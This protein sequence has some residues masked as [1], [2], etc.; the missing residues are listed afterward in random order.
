MMKI[1]MLIN[2]IAPM[3]FIFV[4]V[5]GL[6]N[7][8]FATTFQL[9]TEELPPYSMMEDNQPVGIS[10]EIVSL[11]FEKAQLDYE[12]RVVPWKRAFNTLQNKV[13]SCAFPVQR[14][15]EREV[16]FHWISPILITHTAFYT[17]KHS[18]LRIRTLED[19]RYLEIGS[20]GGSAIVDYLSNL[21]FI[22]R[23]TT[24]E[25]NNIHKLI[26]NRIDIWAADTNTAK[27]YSK[28]NNVQLKRHVVFFTTLRALACNIGVP[29]AVIEKLQITLKNMYEDGSISAV[30]NKYQ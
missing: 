28:K 17:N 1:V 25:E 7:L 4:I 8:T 11:L 24:K 26:H 29:D 9:Y 2:C 18:S 5:A 20:Y 30:M 14:N 27:Y 22:V 6:P 13:D 19:A 23:T 16:V 3:A 21:K 15:Q 12:V 10:V